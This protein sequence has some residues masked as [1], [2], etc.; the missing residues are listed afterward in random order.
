M[1]PRI[2]LGYF[3]S[4]LKRHVKHIHRASKN[5]GAMKFLVNMPHPWPKFVRGDAGGLVWQKIKNPNS[6]VNCLRPISHMS[7]CR[8]MSCQ[9]EHVG[10]R[11]LRYCL[12]VP[13]SN[14]ILMLDTDPTEWKLL[15][16]L[17][18][19]LLEVG[20]SKKS[21]IW[22]E[23]YALILNPSSR[24]IHSRRWA[25]CIVLLALFEY[26]GK[27]NILPLAWSTNKLPQ[28]YPTR[29]LPNVCGRQLGTWEK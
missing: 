12:Y 21:I 9:V 3:L 28:V 5:M 2:P 17:L 7:F 20:S 8:P 13:F 11:P 23:W 10:A 25:H 14:P 4:I 16:L 6:V 15:L 26:C 22:S 27:L 1:S 19:M 18:A 29:S 24:A